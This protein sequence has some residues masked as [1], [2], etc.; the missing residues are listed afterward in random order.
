MEY[1]KT[2]LSFFIMFVYFVSNGVLYGMYSTNDLQKFNMLKNWEG[3]IEQLLPSL[4]MI[5]TIIGFML[6]FVN[7]LEPGTPITPEY[8]KNVMFPKLTLGLGTAT[9]TTIVGLITSLLLSAK[10]HMLRYV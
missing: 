3:Y 2:Y 6:L 10:M 8:I 7:I 9:M 4:G 5:G 1:D